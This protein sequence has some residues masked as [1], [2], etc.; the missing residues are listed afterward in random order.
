MGGA[1]GG[2]GP[3]RRRAADRGRHPDRALAAEADPRGRP[4]QPAR[5]RRAGRHQPRGHAPR[6]RRTSSTRPT[7]R[8]R[9]S[10]RSAATW[11]RTRAARTASSTASRRTTSCGLE[12]VLP[13]GEM[14]QLGG[15]ELDPPGYDLLG[16]F[17]GSEG[18]LGIATKVV[19]ARDARARDGAD[20]R[21]LLRLHARR[22]ARR[23]RRSCRPAIVPGAIEMMDKLAIQASEQMAHAGYPGR[24]RRGAAGRARRRRARVRGALRRGRGDLRDAA[25][26]TTSASRATRPSASCSGRRARRRSRRWAGSPPTTSSR[27][28]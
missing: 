20:A 25:A 6:S 2:L 7:R 9:S 3:L 28:A 23:S 8:A 10:A 18:T 22:P 13:D 17:V 15:K 27:T 4:R 14:I 5:V 12:L 19:A 21:R 16:A 26:P 24:P 1:R 11:P